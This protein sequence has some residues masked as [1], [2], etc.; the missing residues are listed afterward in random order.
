MYKAIP[1]LLKFIIILLFAFCIVSP[2]IVFAQKNNSIVFKKDSLRQKFE[3]DSSYLFR[4]RK[5]IHYLNIDFKNA[6]VS[7]NFV[8]LVGIRAGITYLNNHNHTF[9][10]G[11]YTL[12]EFSIFKSN[13][14]KTYQFEA[15]D[16]FIL[17]YEFQIYDGKVFD[18]L[19][20]FDLGFGHYTANS[21]Q[22]PEISVLKSYMIPAGAG[23]KCIF[24]PHTWVGIKFEGGIVMFWEETQQIVLD[25]VYFSVGIRIDVN[26]MIKDLRFIKMKKRYREQIEGLN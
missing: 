15:I 20:P 8:S 3:L 5:V 11:F 1:P 16:Y 19:L 22:S 4:K 2:A 12:N 7:K 17:F 24:M 10:L 14:I 25:G 9:G 6:Y 26:H 18:V 21:T 13:I 23:I